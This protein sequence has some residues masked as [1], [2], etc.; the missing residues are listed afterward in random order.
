MIHKLKT[1]DLPDEIH[2]TN[3]E[4]LSDDSIEKSNVISS[5]S[6]PENW[7]YQKSTYDQKIS[8]YEFQNSKLR[9]G[10]S[11]RQFPKIDDWTIQRGDYNRRVVTKREHVKNMFYPSNDRLVL[12][13]VFALGIAAIYLISLF[14]GNYL[15]NI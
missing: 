14:L 11:Q 8:E 5:F 13:V 7:W 1:D 12:L 15:S 4:E 2:S 3:D 6:L 10:K 9:N